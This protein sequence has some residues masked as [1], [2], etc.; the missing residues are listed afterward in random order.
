MAEGSG[1]RTP[2]LD[3]ETSG[4]ARSREFK[5]GVGGRNP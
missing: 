5:T 4:P 2:P 3:P 1:I